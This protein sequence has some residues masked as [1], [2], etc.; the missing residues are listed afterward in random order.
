M[1]LVERY[2]PTPELAQA[3]SIHAPAMSV[4]GLYNRGIVYAEKSLALRRSFNDLW[5]QGQSL[6][7]YAVVLYAASRFT[8]CIEK[9]REAVRLLQRTGDYWEM[10]I[11]RYQMAAA[12]FRLGEHREALREARRMHESGLEL[13][14]EQA[15]GI[16]LDLWAFATAGHVPEELVKNALKCDRRDAQG[17]A[18]VLLADG[19]RLMSHRRYEE[20]EGRFVEALAVAHRAG[21]MNVFVAPNLS[22]LTTALRCQAETQT[23]FAVTQRR[24]LL[25][26]AAKTARNAL[27]T[28]AWIKNDLPHALRECGRIEALKGRTR[29]AFRRFAQ[30]MAVAERQGAKYE[31]RRRCWLTASCARPWEK[32][33]RRTDSPRQA[34]LAAVSIP[35]ETTEPDAR[36]LPRTTLSL[37]DRFQS[38]L[39]DGR[40]IASALSPAM[41]YEEVRRSAQRLLRCEHCLVLEI[42]RNGEDDDIVPVAGDSQL[43]FRASIVRFALDEGRAVTKDPVNKDAATEDEGNS[44]EGDRAGAAEERSTLCAPIF[45]RGRAAA[46][47]YAAHYQVQDLFGADEERLANFIATIAGAAL[48][49]ADGFQQLQEPQCHAGAARGGQDCRRGGA[50]SAELARSN[51]ELEQ[52]TGELRLTEEQLRVAKDAAES[53]NRARASF[54]P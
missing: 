11:A 37:A 51:H 21:V 36:T 52:L 49:N 23:S 54:W 41:A 1:N 30:S 34:A 7:F 26:R 40:K 42:R 22:W 29:H 38:V 13:G 28:A 2:P 9:A 50:H 5:G 4:I 24:L 48:E 12:L 8:A 33:G 18:Q 39:E 32:Q 44:D 17:N 31:W 15:A 45:V 47:V 3:Y 14:D 25:R 20:A 35:N 10:N 16:S 53:A 19:V 46:C 6:D 27:R 43:G